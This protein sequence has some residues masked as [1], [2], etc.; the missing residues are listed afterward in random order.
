MYT[1]GESEPTVTKYA[2]RLC[3]AKAVD[4]L[5]FIV[6]HELRSAVEANELF[7]CKNRP[8][9]S[10]TAGQIGEFATNREYVF[11]PDPD[12]RLV[13]DTIIVTNSAYKPDDE[14]RVV[15]RLQAKH[16]LGTCP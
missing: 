6:R 12:G 11:R 16:A 7:S 3:G 15:A 1:S 13:L 4:E 10:C 5:G 2:R 14:A 8:R 9:P